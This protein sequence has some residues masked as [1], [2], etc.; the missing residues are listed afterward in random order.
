M[1]LPFAQ[2]IICWFVWKD[3]WTVTRSM[4]RTKR[5]GNVWVVQAI[6]V[7]VHILILDD[8]N[9]LSQNCKRLADGLPTKVKAC[10][11][12]SIGE[13]RQ[14]RFILL[15]RSPSTLQ[16]REEN[17]SQHVHLIFS[18]EQKYTGN[19]FIWRWWMS[20]TDIF[21]TIKRNNLIVIEKCLVQRFMSS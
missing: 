13:T 19:L 17:K 18:I 21:I 2:K 11:Q 7:T 14:I 10:M 5:N 9:I 15:S 12:P 6:H 20:T 1:I 8:P 16:Q 3:S 4:C